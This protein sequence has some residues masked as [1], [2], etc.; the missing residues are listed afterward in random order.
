VEL[1][2]PLTIQHVGLGSARHILYVPSVDHSDFEAMLLQN[3]VKTCKRLTIPTCPSHGFF[4]G[5][6]A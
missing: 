6:W 5:L 2:N 1:L 4:A 3:L